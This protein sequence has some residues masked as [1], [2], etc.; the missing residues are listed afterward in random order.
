[1]NALQVPERE[2]GTIQ[3]SV[4]R[5][6]ELRPALGPILTSFQGVLETRAELIRQFS[7]EPL[8]LP[9]IDPR[10]VAQGLPVLAEAPLFGLEDWLVRSW[11]TMS[12]AMNASMPSGEGFA[13]L[14]SL[15]EQGKA[16]PVDLARMFLD[17]DVERMKQAAGELGLDP[18][19]LRYGLEIVL[20]PVLAAVASKVREQLKK[21]SWS[22]GT[23]PVCG[24]FPSIAYL[25]KPEKVDLESLVGGG[26]QKYLHCSLC[27]FEWRFRR[28]A[29]PACDS[30]ESGIRRIIHEEKKPYERA[31]AC[32]SCKAYF[33]CLDLREY[34]EEPNL[35][36]APLGLMHLDFIAARE[37]FLP[38]APTPWNVLPQELLQPKEADG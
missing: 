4:H 6:V 21:I 16:D 20:G 25:A 8:D 9:A 12:K 5:Y 10:R 34:D 14:L 18:G 17:R 13:A 22:Q 27:A 36:V 35:D 23:C 7:G 1:M 2:C 15:L 11:R 32:T 3:E 33:L 19:L 24:S 28:D 38:L 29:C 30:G 37:G 26:G 31:E